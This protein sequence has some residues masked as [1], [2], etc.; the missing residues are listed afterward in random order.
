VVAYNWLKVF[1]LYQTIDMTAA[2][3]MYNEAINYLFTSPYQN[4]INNAYTNSFADRTL[5]SNVCKYFNDPK[6]CNSYRNG[7]FGSG[8]S[9]LVPFVVK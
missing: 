1:S 9:M 5:N 3:A 8:F 2:N 4:F 7:L 6:A